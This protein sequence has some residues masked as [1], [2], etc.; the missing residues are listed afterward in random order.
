MQN[1]TAFS[2]RKCLSRNIHPSEPDSVRRVK[3]SAILYDLAKSCVSGVPPPSPVDL[4]GIEIPTAQ[5][6]CRLDAPAPG[7]HAKA[8]V[9]VKIIHQGQSLVEEC[10]SDANS[11]IS[12]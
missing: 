7:V 5:L 3:T 2:A 6:Y 11:F 4:T 9:V 8:I 12:S 1:A 10:W